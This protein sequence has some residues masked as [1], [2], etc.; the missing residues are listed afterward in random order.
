[1]PLFWSAARN[2]AAPIEV[3]PFAS[4]VKEAPGTEA[5]MTGLPPIHPEI[6]LSTLASWKVVTR[7]GHGSGV[8]HIHR[9]RIGAR[10]AFSE[11]KDRWF[12]WKNLMSSDRSYV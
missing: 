5:S 3:L 12:G 7:R 2:W 10:Y 1:L 6:E 9:P 4:P 11:M 8:H